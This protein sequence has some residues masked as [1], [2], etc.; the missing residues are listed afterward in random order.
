MKANISPTNI[1]TVVKEDDFLV[2]KTDIKGR[3][4]YANRNFLTIAG[5]S[6]A[7]VLGKQHN[8]V[9]HPDMPRGIF[10]LLWETL[11]NGCEFNGYVK[12][13]RQDGGFY[14]VFAN[15]SLN[16]S[17]QGVTK[18]FCSVRRKPKPEAVDSITALYQAMLAEEKKV[19]P[20]RAITA[21]SAV[22]K[23]WLKGKTGGDDYATFVLTL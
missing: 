11:Q 20:K 23:N 4:T 16:L 1:E 13:L 18:G 2:S 5:Y 12:N 3:I 6:E 19:G 10:A 8:I 22:L 9:R 15:I 17:A 14:W 21:S 7:Q